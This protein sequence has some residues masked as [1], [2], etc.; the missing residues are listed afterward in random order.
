M[1]EKMHVGVDEAG[2]QGGVAEVED[3]R[4]LRVVDR[5]A[6]GADAVTLDEDFAGLKKRAGVDLE[7]AGGVEDDGRGIGLLRKGE[8]CA[9]RAKQNCA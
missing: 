7:Q 5:D 1:Q 6:D 4:A 3:A 8:D 9:G 2:E